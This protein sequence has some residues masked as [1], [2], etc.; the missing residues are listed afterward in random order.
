MTIVSRK[1]RWSH[2]GYVGPEKEDNTPPWRAKSRAPGWGTR[3][4]SF[5]VLCDQR[6]AWVRK[7]NDN[8]YDKDNTPTL[9]RKKPRTRMGHPDLVQ[10]PTGKGLGEV[11]SRL[12]PERQRSKRP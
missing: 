8:D 9:A 12:A 10:T 2:W 7:V 3:I 5:G 11:S 4:R 6:T 1:T